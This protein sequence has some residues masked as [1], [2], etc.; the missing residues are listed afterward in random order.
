MNVIDL[1]A[2]QWLRWLG[3]FLAASWAFFALRIAQRVLEKDP[4]DRAQELKT[5]LL[6][7]TAWAVV[8]LFVGMV[9]WTVALGSIF[10]DITR[11]AGPLAC[12]Q[13][14]FELVSQSYSYRPGQQGVS[15]TFFCV[16]E[17]GAREEVTGT[18]IV[19]AGLLYSALL[20][21][22]WLWLGKLGVRVLRLGP[23][24]QPGESEA[25]HEARVRRELQAR[26]VTGRGPPGEP[27][28][29]RDPAERL[30]QL[31]RLRDVGLIDAAD[32]DARKARILDDI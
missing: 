15:R 3:W 17:G 18:T 24:R 26:L 27:P 21:A 2:P 10:P 28:A 20:L 22:G 1:T 31:K 5:L 23:R 7:I 9:L 4:A 30:S 12:P 6:G 14:Q 29:S 13:G 32:F 11:I 8:S 25:D 19:Y 16:H